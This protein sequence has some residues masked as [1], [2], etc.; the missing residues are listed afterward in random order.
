MGNMPEA[1]QLVLEPPDPSTKPKST[2]QPPQ[3]VPPLIPEGGIGGFVSDR[4]NQEEFVPSG[5]KIPAEW[6]RF[7][8]PMSGRFMPYFQ[9]RLDNPQGS[10]IVALPVYHKAF[11]VLESLIEDVRLGDWITVPSVIITAGGATIGRKFEALT[12]PRQ[13]YPISLDLHMLGPVEHMMGEGPIAHCMTDTGQTVLLKGAAFSAFF[14]KRI[15]QEAREVDVLPYD[16]IMGGTLYD[17]LG[18]E[19]DATEEELKKAYR[20]KAMELHPDRNHEEDAGARFIEVKE[21]YDALSDPDQR[22]CLDMA[23]LMMQSTFGSNAKSVVILSGKHKDQLWPPI[24]SGKI[25][26]IGTVIGGSILLTSLEEVEPVTKKGMTRVA[27][28]VDG[29][30]TVYWSKERP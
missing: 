26:G 18:V 17:V 30:P 14:G 15:P 5:G 21:A 25:K 13:Y 12:V 7:W 8:D 11:G 27:A 10:T 24:S 29:I 16:T 3:F 23:M 20:Q 19:S 9:V 4:G 2:K 22:K 1:L 28:I 6:R